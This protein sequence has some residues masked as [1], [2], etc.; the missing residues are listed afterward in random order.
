MKK[1]LSICRKIDKRRTHMWHLQMMKPWIPWNTGKISGF[2][3]LKP[4]S[5]L[6]LTMP[7][8]KLEH[9]PLLNAFSNDETHWPDSHKHIWIFKHEGSIWQIFSPICHKPTPNIE[10]GPGQMQRA[11]PETCIPKPIPGGSITA[12]QKRAGQTFFSISKKNLR[13]VLPD[14]P[15]NNRTFDER[16]WTGVFEKKSKTGFCLVWFGF[17]P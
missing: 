14:A 16:L 6:P 2:H 9:T 3:M 8:T 15:E 11:G 1:V 4:G 7:A 5:F 12:N 17:C 13:W 10:I